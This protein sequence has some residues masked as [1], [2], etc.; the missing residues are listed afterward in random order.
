MT[1]THPPEFKTKAAFLEWMVSRADSLAADLRRSSPPSPSRP[2]IDLRLQMANLLQ[3]ADFVMQLSEA[4]ATVTASHKDASEVEYIALDIGHLRSEGYL[5]APHEE[6]ALILRK[7]PIVLPFA[8]E[9]R[10]EVGFALRIGLSG[11]EQLLDVTTTQPAF[12][13]KRYWF[14]CPGFEHGCGNRVLRIYRAV[15]G[16]PF[17]C[18]ACH[19][20]FHDKGWRTARDRHVII[21]TIQHAS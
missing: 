2:E 1:R 17:A 6:G 12:G 16:G 7:P 5:D 15:G 4:G 3:C 8:I 11:A 20:A 10:P 13:G 19:K 9:G 14:V 18:H 21:S